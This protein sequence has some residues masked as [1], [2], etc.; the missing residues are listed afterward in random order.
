MIHVSIKLRAGIIPGISD[1]FEKYLGKY[2][3]PKHGEKTEA[4]LSKT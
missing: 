4:D 2:I 1:N 3:H